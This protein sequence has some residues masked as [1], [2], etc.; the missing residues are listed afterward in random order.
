MYI[1]ICMYREFYK[2]KCILVPILKSA[3]TVWSG[4]SPHVKERRPPTHLQSSEGASGERLGT[5]GPRSHPTPLQQTQKGGGARVELRLC[6][7]LHQWPPPASPTQMSE[8]LWDPL[9][10]SQRG[11][12]GTKGLERTDNWNL[13]GWDGRWF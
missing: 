5:Q 9:R 12:R 10:T 6:P 3:G 7:L 13:K 1:K 4:C 11:L 8:V 2:Y